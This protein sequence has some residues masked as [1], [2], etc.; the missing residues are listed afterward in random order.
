MTGALPLLCNEVAL[1]TPFRRPLRPSSPT[2]ST[3]GSAADPRILEA[4]FQAIAETLRAVPWEADP[5]T[6]EITY[7]G[8][9][10]KE[11]TGYEVEQWTGG[12]WRDAIHPE[13]RDEV[14][15]RYE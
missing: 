13:D 7:V 11:L 5:A 8:P 14:I 15:R 10:I 2:M 3:G 4:R 6:D 1:E 9:Q 12:R